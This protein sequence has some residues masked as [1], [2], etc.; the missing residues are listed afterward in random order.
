M[1]VSRN[2]THR[3]SGDKAD[4]AVATANATS[5]VDAATANAANR[6]D[7]A[8]AHGANGADAATGNDANEVDAATANAVDVT[9]LQAQVTA[10]QAQVAALQAQVA[11]LQADVVALQARAA[12]PEAQ[13]A[14]RGRV[15]SAS[16][17]TESS[18]TEEGTDGTTTVATTHDDVPQT[19]PAPTFS[20]SDY[21]GLC[22]VLWR[23]ILLGMVFITTT[24]AAGCGIGLA[25]G[26]LWR[27][28]R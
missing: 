23:P 28:W 19:I 5:D 16:W 13:V 12:A 17:D 14:A 1:N 7:A 8:T 25:G 20:F 21:L 4:M 26:T 15:Q 10:L 18:D 6:V 24:G 3:V 2:E 11:A 22:R 9:A 27:K